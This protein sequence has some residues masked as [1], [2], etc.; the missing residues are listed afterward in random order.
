MAIVIFHRVINRVR[1]VNK[2]KDKVDKVVN[3]S[4]NVK[5]NR[6]SLKQIKYYD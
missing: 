2:K 4:G 6:H 3:V 1:I 5:L